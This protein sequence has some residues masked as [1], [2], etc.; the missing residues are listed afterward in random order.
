LPLVLGLAACT[1]TAAGV[2]PPDA[3]LGRW[4]G[5]EGT[6]L[7]IA[8]ANGAYEITVK[9]L[10]GA[11]TFAGSAA[12]DHIEFR[13]DGEALQLRATDGEGT[14]MKWLGDKRNCLTIEL[15]EGYCRD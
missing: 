9:D 13:R 14:G 15:G 2:P 11:R 6:Y 12:R 3:W 7:E 10:D 8:G 1:P 5:P 4:H